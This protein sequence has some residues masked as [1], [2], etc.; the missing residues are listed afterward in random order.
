MFP[1]DDRKAQ[2]LYHECKFG[3]YMILSDNE[4]SG[5]VS[6][7]GAKENLWLMEF[8]GSCVTS[9][10]GEGVVLIPPSSTHIP[11]SFKLELKNTNNIGEYE[12]LLL[13]LAKAKKLR[14][15]LLQV[16][17]DAELIMEQVKGL[18]NV[19]NERLKH[20]C[21]RVW[22]EIED[23]DAFSIEVIPREWKSKE[24]SLAV[25]ASLLIPHPEFVDDVYQ[26]ELIYRPSVLD[27]SEFCQVF[28]NDKQINNFMQCVETFVTTYFEGSDAECKEFSLEQAKELSDGIMQLKGNKIPKGLFFLE[29][30]FDRHDAYKKRKDRF[31]KF[32][33][34]EV[35]K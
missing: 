20:Y 28:E 16:K 5:S 29:C 7:S 15:K 34:L 11:F 3:N 30:L 35:M 2:I 8:D 31:L 32:K 6:Q 4:V 19:K 9:G 26:V 23:F 25:S 12:A 14:V 1:S 33:M 27:N 22:D 10:S 13:G 21:N 18:F 24:D 17:G